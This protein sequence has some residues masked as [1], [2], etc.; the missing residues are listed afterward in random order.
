M[1]DLLCRK[2]GRVAIAPGEDAHTLR[3]SAFSNINLILHYVSL[4]AP[5]P[6]SPNRLHDL[7]RANPG[8]LAPF[9]LLDIGEGRVRFK[10][11]PI[12][13]FVSAMRIFRAL[14]LNP[15]ESQREALLRATQ[16]LCDKALSIC[17]NF[18]WA[19]MLKA[20]CTMMLDMGY[21]EAHVACY[22]RD[23]ARLRS[24]GSSEHHINSKSLKGDTPAHIAAA[25][26]ETSCIQLLAEWKADFTSAN[27]QAETPVLIAHFRLSE[28]AQE[29]VAAGEDADEEKVQLNVLE[30]T[31]REECFNV[32]TTLT[33]TDLSVL[34]H[35]E[36]NHSASMRSKTLLSELENFPHGWK[37]LDLDGW[38]LGV[39][40]PII[41]W[42]FCFLD[43]QD[44]RARLYDAG[45]ALLNPTSM[46][47]LQEA[48]RQESL[49]LLGQIVSQ[50]LIEIS[51]QPS[52]APHLFALFKIV[53]VV[54]E[55]CNTLDEPIYFALQHFTKV[56]G[57]LRTNEKKANFCRIHLDDFTSDTLV[58]VRSLMEAGP[59]KEKH[60]IF[61]DVVE[62]SPRTKD[63]PPMKKSQPILRPAPAPRASHSPGSTFLSG[64][65]SLVAKLPSGYVKLTQ[66][67]QSVK[68]RTNSSTPKDTHTQ[69]QAPVSA[70]S[71]HFEHAQITMRN[72]NDRS[73][74]P[75]HKRSGG[76]NT[77]TPSRSSMSNSSF[78]SHPP[79]ICNSRTP[80]TSANTN[81][82][83]PV[84]KC[85]T[86]ST[87]TSS[88][89]ASRMP[90]PPRDS[91]AFIS[92]EA[93]AVPARESPIPRCAPAARRK[94]A[95]ATRS[96]I[97]DFDIIV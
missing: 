42:L 86:A 78:S 88:Q 3:R 77:K 66:T 69:M 95:S 37:N 1:L 92:P 26:A 80:R 12:L 15:G 40:V 45:E 83:T 43:H 10:S 90:T 19:Q 59:P 58:Y 14:R 16:Q 31:R 21:S 54:Q 62:I 33:N 96:S 70:R 30:F 28:A 84:K 67:P 29:M 63:S 34:P 9:T 47:A 53:R 74:S 76:S 71:V 46:R 17:P 23:L 52:P 73:T 49:H 11:M 18:L 48:F 75:P 94:P 24:L 6:L 20:D 60:V 44:M 89:Y 93:A 91:A 35:L 32:L 22:R 8:T 41:K 72:C 68:K 82:H 38:S 36:A 61:K 87:R 85:Q 65:H 13:D 27:E 4:T 51:S 39:A 5:L 81:S 56:L 50:D 64:S 57:S 55:A 79:K 25:Q 97:E 2:F 7:R